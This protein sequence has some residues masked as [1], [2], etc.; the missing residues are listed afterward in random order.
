MSTQDLLKVVRPTGL[1]L[2]DV[3]LD[4]IA[5]RTESRDTELRYR[6][7]LS[8]SRGKQRPILNFTP[9]GKL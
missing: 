2:P 4:A 3:L 9:R 5:S 1:V 7:N 8:K 6:G